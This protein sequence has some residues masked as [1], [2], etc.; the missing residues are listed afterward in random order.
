MAEPNRSKLPRHEPDHARPDAAAYRVGVDVGGTFTDA[1]VETADGVAVAAFKVPSTTADPSRAVRDCLERLPSEVVAAGYELCHGTTIGTNALIERNG[2]RTALIATRGFKDVIAL[3]RQAR[4]A[5]FSLEQRISVPLVAPELRFEI[6]GR[7]GPDG[8]VEQAL[9]AVEV[10]G[11]AE[12][13]IDADVAAVVVAL[14]H[15][16]ANPSHERAVAEIVSRAMPRAFVTISS[17]VAP[18]IGEFERTSTAVVNG[19]IG[20][21][22]RSYI[23]RL[24]DEVRSRG[25]LGFSIVKSN[26]GLTSPANARDFPVHLVES[27]PA[28]GAVAAAALGRRLG[29][30][31][32]IAFDMGGTTAKVAVIRD[33]RPTL[34]RDFHADRF[35]EGR[36]IGGFPIKSPVVD[37]IEIGAGGGSI[38]WLDP[39][40]VLKI[41]PASAGADPGPACYGRGG[42]LPTLTDAHLVLGNI[43]PSAFAISGIDIVLDHA[44]RAIESRIAGPLGWSVFRAAHAM[45][46][47]ANARMGDMVRLATVGRGLD[48]RDFTLLAYGGGG[49]LHAAEIARALG[50]S[51][52]LVPVS[53][54]MFSARGTL[55]AEIR[56]DLALTRL[57]KIGDETQVGIG[58]A[59]DE[60]EARAATLFKAERRVK[61]PPV[62]RRSI[63]ARYVG[64]LFQMEVVVPPGPID[65]HALEARFRTAY[66]HDFGYDLPELAVQL[67]NLKISASRAHPAEA[68]GNP[69]A[70]TDA[71][72]AP[73]HMATAPDGSRFRQPILSRASLG[74]RSEAGPLI[75]VDHGATVLVPA[76][77][78][79][80]GGH[81]ALTIQVQ[82]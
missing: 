62:V 24:G 49:P 51:T 46:D 82:S 41:G 50:I 30:D 45:I 43:A 40:G 22:V 39:F 70:A 19:Y 44:A 80:A 76:A 11:L 17:D 78:R 69:L 71:I 8:T 14:L 74:D 29:L 27:G 63:E 6:A 37:L 26:G 53:P 20:P 18:E 21:T 56:H 13:L 75:V 9:D 61:E 68:T 38:A 28:A 34:T 10:E 66:Q 81:G 35:S 65:L 72:E 5:L 7:I 15:S 33:G 42:E 54:G 73:D 55:R 59:F 64:Q 57:R 47:I 67:V 32:I 77:A 52:V 60:L 25:A 79:I 1:I 12:H 48:P 58:S 31:R 4:P 16:Y 23:S 2:G 3:R 36:D